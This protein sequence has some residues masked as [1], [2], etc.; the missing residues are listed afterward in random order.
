[1][2]LKLPLYI[3]FLLSIQ[4]YAQ[5][6][7][8][9]ESNLYSDIDNNTYETEEEFSAEV[10]EARFTTLQENSQLN[11]TYNGIIESSV[12]SY[13][14][15]SKS[16]LENLIDK[17]KL[18]F[19]IFEKHL[20]AFNIPDEIKYLAVVESRL[21]PKARSHMGAKGLWQFMY[22]TA[23][24]NGLKINNIVDERL[25]PIKSTKAACNYLSY[26]YETFNDWNLALAAYNAG[27]GNVRKAIRRSGGHRDFWKIRPYLPRETRKYIPS[28]YATY[29]MFEYA[30]THSVYPKEMEIAFEDVRIIEVENELNF[31]DIQEHFK[32]DAKLLHALNPQYKHGKIPYI[33][34]DK[35]YLILPNSVVTQIVPCES[36]VY[37]LSRKM[38]KHTSFFLGSV[39]QQKSSS[40]CGKEKKYT[41]YTVKEG[42]SLW[43]I[44]KSFSNVTIKQLKSWNNLWSTP[45]LKPGTKLKILTN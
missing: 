16:E 5:D 42:E 39:K 29:Y 34:N 44:S 17:S 4:L 6:I 45:Y 43:M 15:A 40:N 11:I 8:Y 30:T 38:M 35:N 2:K 32:I 10:L 14:K 31:K 23:K 36:E 13:L 41:T 28:F 37:E 7:A 22:A 1:M 26:L 12:N 18:Y 19:P 3:I 20:K 25:D 27:P 21:D 24:E 9:N 33:E